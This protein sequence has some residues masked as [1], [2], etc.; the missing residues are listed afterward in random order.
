MT[1]NGWHR[2]FLVVSVLW[3]LLVVA[4]AV[5]DLP[6]SASL[7]RDWIFDELDPA[8]C[9]RIEG[10]TGFGVEP[11]KVERIDI[12]FRAGSAPEAEQRQVRGING[13]LYV[14]PKKLTDAEIAALLTKDGLTATGSQPLFLDVPVPVLIS[15]GGHDLDVTPDETDRDGSLTATAFADA[16]QK[17]LT[18]RR[19]EYAGATTTVVL[20]PLVLIYAFGYSVASVR[21][22]SRAG[23]PTRPPY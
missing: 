20:A 15:V 1:L 12:K 10:C 14:V 7:R 13:T 2:L 11:A 18:T 9:Q 8:T 16:A 22:W 3:S 21:R 23:R 19:A 6:T 5:L 4:V 17:A